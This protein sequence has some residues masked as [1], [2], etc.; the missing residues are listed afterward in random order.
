MQEAQTDIP[1]LIPVRDFCDLLGISLAHGYR[2]IHSGQVDAVRLGKV[3]D[4]E[5]VVGLRED[6]VLPAPPVL[7]G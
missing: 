5:V 7:G 1:P 6:R 2:L 4:T 3:V